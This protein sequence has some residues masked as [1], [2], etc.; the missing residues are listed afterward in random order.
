MLAA[1]PADKFARPRCRPQLHMQRQITLR[2]GALAVL[3][4]FTTMLMCAPAGLGDLGSRERALQQSVGQDTSQIGAYRGRLRDVQSRLDSLQSSLAIQ[5]KVLGRSEGE[6]AQAGARLTSLRAELA[7]DRKVLAAQLVSQYE[8]PSPDLVDVVLESRGFS[9]L[10]ERIDQMRRIA[11]QNANVIKQVAA[12]EMQVRAQ[13]VR[14]AEE[15][16]RQRR[17][18]AAVAVERDQVVGLRL[19][20][21]ERE[22][23]TARDRARK[24]AELGRVK[25]QLAILQTRAAAQ[26]R[27]AYAGGGLSGGP[28]PDNGQYGFFA[29]PGTNY[30]FGEEPEIAAR[31][32]R[33]GEALHLHL[34]GI[35][36][37]RTPQ[38][39]VEVGGYADDPHTRGE[40][41]D[42]PGIEGVPEQI[43]LRFGLTRPFPG[44]AEA[45]HI[46]LA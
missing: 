24:E 42:T 40:A 26:Q 18:T 1:G 19:A 11:K 38:H 29:A 14:L 28:A 9:D 17:V 10:L 15:V 3:A 41:S 35:S 27:A 30:S 34:I 2:R 5:Q 31:L 43:L 44:P 22:R 37:Y 7:G 13:T 46:Q 36:G 12:V 33:L 23:T 45:D 8:S 25:H 4:S 16:A 6:L 20:V 21:L 32:N 39:S